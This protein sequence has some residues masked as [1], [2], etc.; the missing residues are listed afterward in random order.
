MGT[1]ISLIPLLGIPAGLTIAHFSPKEHTSDKKYYVWLQRILLGTIIG[2][3]AWHYN[4]LLSALGILPLFFNPPMW[5]I[6]LLGIPATLAEESHI[7]IF[8]YLLPTATLHKKEWKK[9]MIMT[10]FYA[11]ITIISQN[12]F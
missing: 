4:P 11:A 8:L 1:L 7:P 10:A 3:T 2:A 5:I 12:F 6:P 9:L